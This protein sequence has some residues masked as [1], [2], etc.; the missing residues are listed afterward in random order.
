MDMAE[1][2]RGQEHLAA[3]QPRIAF[4]HQ[5]AHLPVASSNRKSVIWPI[6]PSLALMA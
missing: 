1:H 4:D 6:T 3:R 2:G 5:P